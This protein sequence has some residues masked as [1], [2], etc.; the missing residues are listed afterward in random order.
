MAIVA[1]KTVSLTF[2]Y[3]MALFLPGFE[4]GCQTS[5]YYRLP[6]AEMGTGGRPRVAPAANPQVTATIAI[7]PGVSA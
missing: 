5:S 7:A 2:A 1:V 4:K 6:P 3:V